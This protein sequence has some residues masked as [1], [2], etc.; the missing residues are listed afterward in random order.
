[1]RRFLFLLFLLLALI[2]VSIFVH[3]FP[4]GRRLGGLD[5]MLLALTLT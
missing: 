4:L 5:P 2:G 1:M 3:F